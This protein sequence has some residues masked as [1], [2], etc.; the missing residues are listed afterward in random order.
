MAKTKALPTL[1]Q[2]LY[3]GNN[4]EIHHKGKNWMN[5]LSPGDPKIP[6][7]KKPDKKNK[8]LFTP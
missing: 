3:K 8:P 1:A 4:Q 7:G 6:T 2:A 5:E